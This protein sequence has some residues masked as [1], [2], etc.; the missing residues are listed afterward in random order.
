MKPRILTGDR[1]T[2]KLHVGH[3]VGHLQQN[4]ALQDEYDTFMLV[5]DLHVL[6]TK[7]DGGDL[8]TNITE[9]VRSYLAV[10]LD[11]QKVTFFV[12]SGVPEIAQLAVILGNYITVN[13]LQRV[14]TLKEVMADLHIEQPPFGLL[15]YPV[16]MAAD[17]L[18]FKANVVPVGEDQLSHLEVTRE[19]ARRLNG[20]IGD[21]LIEP[22]PK[23]SET[24][25][26][27]GTDGG[28]K[29]SKSLGNTIEL[30]ATP[31]ELKKKVMSMFTDPN[32]K[33]ATDPGTV[34]GNPVFLYH[35]V[36]NADK[37]EV[38]SLK[39]RYRQG[40][41]GDVEV[42]EKLLVAL[43]AVLAPIRERGAA[44]SDEQIARLLR[45]GTAKARQVARETLDQVKSALG[46]GGGI[47]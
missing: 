36:F 45:D 40:Q 24:K 29:M 17:I 15:G 32:R 27:P 22:T 2:G 1:P 10:G 3:L 18:S 7:P 26:L 34:E 33:S 16:L 35:D 43:E 14:P 6:T 38:E 4:V 41:V 25:R 19:L 5:A 11:P 13:R 30:F 42:K 21:I 37:A 8:R 46:L 31:E 23:I 12:Q 47:L 39:N 9:L 44:V 20:Q 28:A